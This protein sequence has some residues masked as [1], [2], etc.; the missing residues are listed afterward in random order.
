MGL[1]GKGKGGEGEGADQAPQ[2]IITGVRGFGVMLVRRQR[3]Q[4]V[5]A[6]LA[7]AGR[8]CRVRRPG[9]QLQVL[10]KREAD[11]LRRKKHRVLRRPVLGSLAWVPAVTGRHRRVTPMRPSPGY[12]EKRHVRAG[13]SKLHRLV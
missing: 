13:R 5:S 7:A 1:Y 4:V 3:K 11:S 9:A 8:R 6:V 10:R 12:A 2:A